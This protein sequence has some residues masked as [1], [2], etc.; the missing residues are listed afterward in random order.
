MKTRATLLARLRDPAS[1]AW[2]E[3]EAAYRG[4]V[5][6]YCRRLGMQPTEGDDVWQ[7]VLMN[8]LHGMSSFQY[9]PQR[10][11]FR[12]YLY[13]AVRNASMKEKDQAKGAGVSW[14]E[15]NLELLE[16]ESALREIWDQEWLDHH[17]RRAHASLRRSFETRSIVVFDQLLAGSTTREVAE[18]QGMSEAAV[19]KVKQRVLARMQAEVEHQIEREDRVW[20]P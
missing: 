2:G 17:C 18:Q 1:D 14:S 15:V 8:L 10:G 16:G 5:A 4:L 19:H 13:R 6:A 11:R 12:A 7:R 20:L 9:D 3:F